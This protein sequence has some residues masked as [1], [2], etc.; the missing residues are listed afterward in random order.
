MM[1]TIH[2]MTQTASPISVA[3]ARK[4]ARPGIIVAVACFCGIVVALTQTLIVPLVP[5]LP[6]PQRCSQRR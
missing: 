3:E 4:V 6:G 5:L 2:I 1:C